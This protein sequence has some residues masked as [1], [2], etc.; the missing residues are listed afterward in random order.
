V[1]HR[2]GEKVVRGVPILTITALHSD[3]VVGYLRQP[4]NTRPTTNTTVIVRTRTQKRQLATGKIERIGSQMELINP[5]LLSTDSN[6]IELG[7][8][9]LVRLPEEMK[10][11]PGEVVDITIQPAGK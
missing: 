7:L 4:I 10:L 2:A 8:P 5:V 3:R 9:F 6:R 11:V 1:Y